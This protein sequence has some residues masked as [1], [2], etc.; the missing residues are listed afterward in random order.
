MCIND[1]A[2]N[3]IGPAAIISQAVC[4]SR[5]IPFGYFKCLSI[6]ERFDRTQDD[7]VSFDQAGESN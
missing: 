6:V 4:H 7:T 5:N 3:F 2:F 1:L